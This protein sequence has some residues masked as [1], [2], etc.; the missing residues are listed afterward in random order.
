[1]GDSLSYFNILL[2]AVQNTLLCLL[3]RII[4]VMSSSSI[5]FSVFY[6]NYSIIDFR[7]VQTPFYNLR[8]TSLTFSKVYIKWVF[9]GWVPC[10]I[11]LTVFSFYFSFIVLLLRVRVYSLRSDLNIA[12]RDDLRM[13]GHLLPYCISYMI[14]IFNRFLWYES[15][16]SHYFRKSLLVPY[17]RKGIFVFD[18]LK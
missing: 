8:S 16:W 3:I 18:S 2:S 17:V 14:F 1:M 12:Y 6:V 9:P 10:N 7:K 15:F 11:T 5:P 13:S 4:L